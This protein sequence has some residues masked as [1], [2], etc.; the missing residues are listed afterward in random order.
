MKIFLNERKLTFDGIEIKNNIIYLN[1]EV[2]IIPY[3]NYQVN[4]DEFTKFL[5]N[6]L[7]NYINISDK[8]SFDILSDYFTYFKITT[9]PIVKENMTIK[10]CYL[11]I[12][13]K[14]LWN[15]FKVIN[16]FNSYK[17]IKIDKYFTYLKI[18]SKLKSV[19][20]S[21]PEFIKFE[22]EEFTLLDFIL[23]YHQ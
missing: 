15:S 20:V 10:I 23:D 7:D 11:I 22:E 8:N 3:E 6:S 16:L 4:L 17:L 1:K 13:C 21:K 18:L 2:I 14:E 19:E 9:N 12:N 5:K